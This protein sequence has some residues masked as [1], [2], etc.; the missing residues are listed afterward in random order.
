MTL[1]LLA[2]GKANLLQREVC[3]IFGNRRFYIARVT[4]YVTG[5]YADIGFSNATLLKLRGQL[6]VCELIQGNNHKA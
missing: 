3:Q 1:R 2:G 6:G 5:Y 4:L